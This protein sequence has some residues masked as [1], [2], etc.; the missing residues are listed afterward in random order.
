[1]RTV[2]GQGFF[3]ISL[4]AVCLFVG[5]SK[6][7][8]G[9]HGLDPSQLNS[10][11]GGFGNTLAIQY[12]GCY[13]LGP[14]VERDLSLPYPASLGGGSKLF[15]YTFSNDLPMTFPGFV[16]GGSQ[17][18]NDLT[19][20]N[21]ATACRAHGFKFTILINNACKCSPYPP[22]NTFARTSI[23]QIDP[24]SACHSGDNCA[25]DPT[26]QA[27]GRSQNNIAYADIFIDATYPDPLQIPAPGIEA[28]KYRYLGC[29]DLNSGGPL[30]PGGFT[31]S[32]TTLNECYTF[33]A[34]YEMAYAGASFQPSA[35]N[36][37]K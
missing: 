31:G 11:P 7:Q 18:N 15:P 16:I 8:G 35:L 17:F 3:P 2:P 32:F 27:C 9:G 13:V 20:L 12:Y 23:S 22:P 21:C 1:M 29:F 30:A 4:I 33:C 5:I 28:G 37:G 26:Q 25:G 24:N 34:R 14:D 10:C 36:G 6:G 19:P